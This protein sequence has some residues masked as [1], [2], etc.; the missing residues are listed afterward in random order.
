MF[1]VF[2]LQ[3]PSANMALL[4]ATESHDSRYA[5]HA[6]AGSRSQSKVRNPTWMMA[7][8]L[9]KKVCGL[10]VDI[11]KLLLSLLFFF[12]LNFIILTNPK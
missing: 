5:K 3:L 7:L 9:F 6:R 11:D 8:C 10:N 1:A 4:S 12:F 2:H